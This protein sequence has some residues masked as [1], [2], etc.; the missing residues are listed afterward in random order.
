VIFTAYMYLF[1]YVDKF[2]NDVKK[3]KSVLQNEIQNLNNL[4]SANASGEL[5]VKMKNDIEKAKDE[6]NRIAEQKNLI[7]ESIYKL[8]LDQE[9]WHIFL[10]Y[11]TQEA[12]KNKIKIKEF[13][14]KTNN[15]IT[16]NISSTTINIDG[17]GDY[18]NILLF[19]NGI[20]SKSEYINIK[21]FSI[22]SGESLTF[23]LSIEVWR[24]DV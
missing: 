19:L 6:I 11:L 3:K 1:P 10:N 15:Q 9:G 13:D 5:L 22:V 2:Y 16:T 23:S 7:E 8:S 12:Q 20:E 24:I 17:S 21:N 18:K 14:I 4:M